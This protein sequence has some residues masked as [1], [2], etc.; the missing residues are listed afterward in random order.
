MSEIEPRISKFLHEKGRKLKLPISG[1][2]EITPLCN[3]DC[4]MCYVHLTKAQMEARGKAMTTD[5]L[6]GMAENAR[7]AGMVFALLTGGEPLINSDFK[8]IYSS[9]KSMGL[10]L[11]LNTNGYLID[12]GMEKYLINNPPSR[13]NISLYGGDDESYKRLCG[14]DDGFTTVSSVIKHLKKAGLSVVVNFTVTAFNAGQ[15]ERI[16]DFCDAL[17]IPVNYS[18]YLYPPVRRVENGFGDNNARFDPNEAA[19]YS[20]KCDMRRYTPEIFKQRASA[21]A[22]MRFVNESDCISN[23]D[24]AG[25]QCRAGITSFWLTWDGRMLPCGMLNQPC[26]YPLKDGFNKAWEQTVDASKRIMLPQ[27]CLSCKKNSLC[28]KCAAICYAE[29]GDFNIVPDYRCRMTDAVIKYTTDEYNKILA[30]DI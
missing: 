29:T 12:R 11:Y 17:N 30:K 5:Q 10:I 8:Y 26:A 1:N 19:F 3:F 2:F 28:G 21:I 6:L 20:V 14:C 18:T 15:I 23:E 9:M 13:I 27:K 4:K 24:N 16:F 25:I 22:K 7:N